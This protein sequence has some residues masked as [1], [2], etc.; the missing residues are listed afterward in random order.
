MRKL[1]EMFSE[2]LHI[3]KLLNTNGNYM[4]LEEIRKSLDL[5][6]EIVI[7]S[8]ACL[9]AKNLVLHPTGSQQ[10]KINHCEET[11]KI[12]ST[13]KNKLEWSWRYNKQ[14]CLY[15]DSDRIFTTVTLKN[16]KYVGLCYHT[17]FN[18]TSREFNNIHLDILLDQI[19]DYLER[20]SFIH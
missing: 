17:P 14:P 20:M 10:W 16:K 4:S 8:L 1:Y 11:E 15:Y 9:Y 19:E 3:L 13:T 18:S 2:D 7:R 12:L 5:E 6:Q